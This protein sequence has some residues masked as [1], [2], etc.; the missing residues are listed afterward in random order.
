MQR[1]SRS[2]H[3][4]DWYLGVLPLLGVPVHW[5]FTWLPQRPA[6]A[7]DIRRKWPVDGSR[8]VSFQPGA[9]WTNKRWPAEHY[10]EVLRQLAARRPDLR[11][12]VLGGQDERTLGESISRAGGGRCLDLTG[13]LSLPEMV[14]WLRRS[15]LLITNDTGPMHVAAAL[16]TPVV[17][18]FGP[19]TPQRTGPYGQLDDVLQLSLPCVPCLKPYCIYPKPME[20]LRALPPSVA[21]Q[22]ALARL[23]AAESVER[24]GGANPPAAKGWQESSA[25]LSRAA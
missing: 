8:W 16:G 15:A 10:A 14:E 12:A 25:L 23:K 22:A 21:V 11:F 24:L 5:N 2:T 7:E 1:R 18:M 4:V 13:K 3:A 20:C 9:R 6:V 17:A 19:T